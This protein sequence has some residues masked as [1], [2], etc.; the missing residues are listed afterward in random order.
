MDIQTSNSRSYSSNAARLRRRKR[1]R[2][3]RLIRLALL[4]VVAVAL[5]LVIAALL[6]RNSVVMSAP[7]EDITEV[8]AGTT[9]TEPT[10][11]AVYRGT[12]FNRKGTPVTV[13]RSGTVNTAV[14]GTYKLTYTAEYK[15]K[16]AASVLNVRVT[17][18]TPPEVALNGDETLFVAQN[19]EF[20]DPGVTATDG[21]EG[22]V[23]ALVTVE[24]KVDTA[25]VGE[26][27]LV[28][29]AKDSSGN[30][31][32][33]TRKVQVLQGE[34][35]PGE[36]VVY[37]TF[38]D[39]PYKHTQ[40]LL[41]ILDKYNV[42]VT[43]FVTNQWPAY[44]DLIGEE[45]RRGH[46]VAVHTY[47]HEYKEVY[48]SAEAYFKDLN[49]M[50]E[51][52]KEQTGS[53]ANIIR[54]PGGASNTIS[55]RYEEGLMTKLTRMVDEKGYKYADWNL[56]SGDADEAKDAKSVYNIVVKGL[57][58]RTKPA[59]ILM[60]DIKS[61]TVDAIEDIIKWGLENGYRFLPMDQSSPMAHQTI[62]N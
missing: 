2:R 23:S 34:T 35:N 42:K 55:R 51:I 20:V 26:Y 30:E 47:S 33:V 25:T 45:A 16:S 4:A 61:Y 3:R 38:D 43:F 21:I 53:Y 49:A 18:K 57:K 5:V 32:L 37:L 59:V 46:T 29:H 58:N 41:D 13:R 12:I 40:R 11:T 14:P 62:L 7:E 22:D 8:A 17:D 50:N 19:S 48:A 15:N 31:S 10:V 36:R 27:T 28:Y 44:K 9:F 24:G 60:H 56:N 6:N 39:G 1:A 54:F 52:I